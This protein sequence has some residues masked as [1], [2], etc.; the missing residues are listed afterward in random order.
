M[1]KKKPPGLDGVEGLRAGGGTRPSAGA[2]AKYEDVA[3]HERSLA[4]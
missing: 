4:C 1:D 2:Q 3:G